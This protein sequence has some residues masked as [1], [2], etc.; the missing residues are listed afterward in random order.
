MSRLYA[1]LSGFW[2][3]R[4]EISV[5]S[6]RQPGKLLAACLAAAATAVLSRPCSAQLDGLSAIGHSYQSDARGGCETSIGDTALAHVR[7]PASVL[8][9]KTSKFD[10]KLTNIFVLDNS[11]S[12]RI[13][14]THSN[15]DNLFA[16]NLGVVQK[17]NERL[18]VGLAFETGGWQT[19]FVN[20][21]MSRRFLTRVNNSVG[22]KTYSITA[23][24]GARAG[25][26]WYLGAGP[27][28][29]IMSLSTDL[30]A[31]AGLLKIPKSWSFG[32]GYQLGAVYHPTSKVSLGVSYSSPSYMTGLSNEFTYALPGNL[33]IK[34]R[35]RLSSITLP[36][37]VSYGVAYLPDEKTK[38]AVE[39]AYLNYGQSLL[40][41]V[42]IDAPVKARF[43]PG[44]R[45]FLVLNVG[46][47]RDFNRNFSGSVGYVFNTKPVTSSQLVPF[48]AA[49]AQNQFTWGLRYKKGR[50]WT[51]FAHIIG[52]PAVTRSSST[53]HIAFGPQ[54]PDST[55]R[56]MLQSFNCGVGFSF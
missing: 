49:N 44:F 13:E 27:H 41:D 20:N 46:V 5:S 28:F 21:A 35:G 32:A 53:A 39:G 19:S 38:V 45:D 9:Q 3:Y 10:S 16:Y 24:L 22:Y 26:K 50:V 54:Y 30:P 12:N 14:K 40:G 18:G 29:N 56:Q 42:K 31:G 43:N 17:L 33:N 52:L 55:V 4:M 25:K 1:R 2:P 15:V 8:L 37:R 7:Q 34:G 23:N 51:G 47:D 6:R 11:W 36:G 48:Y